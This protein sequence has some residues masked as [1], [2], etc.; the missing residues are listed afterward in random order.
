LAELCAGELALQDGRHRLTIPRRVRNVTH[1][2]GVAVEGQQRFQIVEAKLSQDQARRAH[3]QTRSDGKFHAK[4][5]PDALRSE[6]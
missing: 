1:R 4:S 5:I 2:V 6:D 3:R